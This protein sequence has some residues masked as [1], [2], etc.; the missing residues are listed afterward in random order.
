MEAT[1]TKKNLQ[2][3][4]VNVAI[5]D[6]DAID[7]LSNNNNAPNIDYLSKTNATPTNNGIT[8]HSILTN[9]SAMGE[10][11]LHCGKVSFQSH[12]TS[13]LT[14]AMCESDVEFDGNTVTIPSIQNRESLV[15]HSYNESAGNVSLYTIANYARNNS[16]IVT[17]SITMNVDIVSNVILVTLPHLFHNVIYHTLTS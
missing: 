12:N 13:Y 2:W 3:Q 11:F 5:N 8:L 17:T 16:N 14:D 1:I 7:N 6:V 15:T 9:A 4:K 10:E